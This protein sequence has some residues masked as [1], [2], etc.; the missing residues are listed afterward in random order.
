M[1]STSL[2]I[3]ET[4]SSVKIYNRYD[5]PAVPA[6]PANHTDPITDNSELS[7][8]SPHRCLSAR[9]D[10]DLFKCAIQQAVDGESVLHSERLVKK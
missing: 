4:R 3:G 2:P 10:P 8:L 6:T 9:L 5:I 1:G 7:Q